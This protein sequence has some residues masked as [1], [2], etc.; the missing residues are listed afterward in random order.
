[1]VLKDHINLPGFACNVRD[2]TISVSSLTSLSWPAPSAGTQRRE[3]RSALLPLQR[4]VQRGLPLPGQEGGQ[5]PQPGGHR[6]PGG[7]PTAGQGGRWV[8]Q[9]VGRLIVS[10][11]GLLFSRWV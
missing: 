11:V 3:V 4:P 9:F 1:M 7:W 6:A 10:L 5:G 2:L 8:G